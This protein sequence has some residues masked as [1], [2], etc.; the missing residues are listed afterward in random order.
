MALVSALSRS[1]G[2]PEATTKFVG[3]L[4]RE[5]ERLSALVS[6]LL[7]LSRLENSVGQ[8]EP[9]ALEDVVLSVTEKLRPRAADAGVDLAVGDL[10]A[11]EVPGREADLELMLHNLLDNAIRYTLTGGT[12]TVA[13]ERRGDTA[14]L[15]VSDT[16]I[17]IPEADLPRI[18]ERFYR[19]GTA[20]TRG[21]AEPASGWPS[22]A[23][24]R[25]PITAPSKWS[26]RPARDPRSRSLFRVPEGPNERSPSR[27]EAFTLRSRDLFILQ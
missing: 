14:S 24:L 21:A 13:L 15:S 20:G 6:D 9:V 16:G 8:L 25:S 4:E 19:V 2:D 11:T 26:A 1:A 3:M 10:P 23:T 7:D 12:I 22:C 17:G 18:F 27:P 5:A